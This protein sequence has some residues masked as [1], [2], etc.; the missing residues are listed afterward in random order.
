M[1]VVRDIVRRFN[2][3]PEFIVVDNGSDFLADAFESFLRAMGTHLR[4]RPAGNPRH[5]AVLERMF[6]RLNTEYIHSL[7]GNTKATKNVRMVT[8]SHLPEKLAEWTLGNLYHGI[9]HW[10][11]EFY[12]QQTHPALDESPREAFMRGLRENGRRPQR[13]I[14]FNRDF[15]IA[16]C[17]PVDRSG[18]RQIHAQRGVKV[19]NRFYWNDAFKS[20]KVAGQS[21]PVRSDPWNASSVYVRLKDRWVQAICRNLHGLGQLTHFEQQAVT[22][23][24]NRRS[25][26]AA[27]DERAAQRLREFMQ[28]FTP[29]GALAIEFER[30]SENKILYNGLQFA[31]IDPTFTAPRGNLIEE[32]VGISDA[33]SNE[34]P[35]ADRRATLPQQSTASDELSDIDDFE[36]F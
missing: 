11:C 31:G 32:P 3:L 7:A 17:P 8:G 34:I 6:G 1:M 14:L 4:F 36:D 16:T 15:L 33:A 2:R 27:G 24:F 35:Q 26:M 23:E 13:Q 22:A 18:V 10:A 21:L 12:D 5:G 29:A 25:S 19:D 9:H 30:Q 28:T 20:S